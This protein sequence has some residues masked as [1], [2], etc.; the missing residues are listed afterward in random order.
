[1]NDSHG[2]I[3]DYVLGDLGDDE[4]RAF[5]ERIAAE[6]TLAREVERMRA[7]LGLLPYAKATEPPPHLRSAVLRAADAARKPRPTRRT[8]IR[9]AWSTFGLAAAALLAVALGIDS[10]R[11]R[12][13]LRLERTVTAMLQE[14][15]I[16]RSFVLHGTGTASGAVGTVALDLDAK[17]GAVAIERL[18]ALP[19][20][21]VY[22][23]WALVGENDVPCGDFGV[24]P[25]G[26]I[27][28]QFPI[29]V[30]SY[31]APIGRLFVTVEPAPAPP[32]PSGPTVMTSA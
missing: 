20:G 3:V 29:P 23:L 19:A 21:Q 1:M 18:P 14:P 13:E 27:V 9:A 31:T 22:R 24:N 28:N 16:V 25:A 12:R 6:P 5:E 2:L 26:K 30:D 4:A 10:Y 17:K 15:N 7:V 32:R 8:T 11:V